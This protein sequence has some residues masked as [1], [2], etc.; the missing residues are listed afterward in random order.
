MYRLENARE[1]PCDYIT[2][3]QRRYFKLALDYCLSNNAIK[4][5]VNRTFYE[6]DFENMICLI[7]GADK[8][9]YR[10]KLIKIDAK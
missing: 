3:T 2:P 9:P 1:N 7:A 6:F 10:H 4:C 8:R 5:Y